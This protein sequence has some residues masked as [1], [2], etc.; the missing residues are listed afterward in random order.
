MYFLKKKSKVLE[1]F[2]DFKA[3]VET[4]ARRKIK[5]LRYDNGGEYIKS[6]FLQ[7][8]AKIGFKIQHTIP[9]TPQ[10]NGVAERKKRVLKE[11]TTCMLESK[12]LAAN[13]CAEDMIIYYYT[14]KMAPH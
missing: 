11:M 8:C 13:I 5:D 10:Q 4:G 6:Y 12:Y 7:L 1:K 3:S 14:N 2:I 9:Y